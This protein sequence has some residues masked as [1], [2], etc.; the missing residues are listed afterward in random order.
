MVT[1]NA[2]LP[3]APEPAQPPSTV[4]A[5]ADAEL[6]AESGVTAEPSV[7]EPKPGTAPK[8]WET[9]DPLEVDDIPDDHPLFQR[10]NE[11]RLQSQVDRAKALIEQGRQQEVPTKLRELVE[12]GSRGNQ[13]DVAYQQAYERIRGIEQAAME[14][15][16]VAQRDWQQ[17]GERYREW[18]GQYLA[19]QRQ[20]NVEQRVDPEMLRSETITN[21]M[22]AFLGSLKEFGALNQTERE[23]LVNDTWQSAK[24]DYPRFYTLMVDWEAD[25]RADKL[26][27]KK[28]AEIGKAALEVASQEAMARSGV[29]DTSGAAADAA[30]WAT[31][32]EAR[33]LHAHGRLSNA[34]MRRINADQSIP[35]GY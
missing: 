25:K 34:Q 8:W 24:Q 17:N 15:D 9:A 30:A 13:Q 28:Q 2:G 29:P 5:P 21:Q 23:R 7:T 22:G 19:Y 31:K 18:S 14:G 3:I 11:R 12:L 16:E 35:D 26:A 32:A 10:I 4:E 27:G 6:R 33:S 20:R 1:D